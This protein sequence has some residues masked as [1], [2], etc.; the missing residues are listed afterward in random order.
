VSEPAAGH[1][2]TEG[3]LTTP[4]EEERDI[5]HFANSHRSLILE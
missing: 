5:I 3:V 1:P 4:G 2:V